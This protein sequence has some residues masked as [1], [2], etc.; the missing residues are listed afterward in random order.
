L[1]HCQQHNK[2][3]DTTTTSNE[4]FFSAVEKKKK[5]RHNKQQQLASFVGVHESFREKARMRKSQIHPLH[6]LYTFLCTSLFFQA[7]SCCKGK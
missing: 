7:L 3:T 2:R 5:A 6:F 1:G 4:H